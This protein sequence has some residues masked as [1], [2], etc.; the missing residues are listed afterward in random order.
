MISISIR[1]LELK[2]VSIP[3]QAASEQ[4][5]KTDDVSR[6]R[7]LMNGGPGDASVKYGL[8]HMT[9]VLTTIYIPGRIRESSPSFEPLRAP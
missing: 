9:M 8:V 2:R 7:E 4:V 5:D 3:L 1:L 6:G